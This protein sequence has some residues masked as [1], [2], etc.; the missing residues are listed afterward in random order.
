MPREFDVIKRHIQK[1]KLEWWYYICSKS[2]VVAFY[3]TW[4]TEL[5][6]L[7]LLQ[8]FLSWILDFLPPTNNWCYHDNNK[9]AT[10]TK[11]IFRHP[12][13]MSNFMQH[14]RGGGRGQN[15][16]FPTLLDSYRELLLSLWAPLSF[17][18]LSSE[19]VFVCEEWW[20]NL[21]EGKK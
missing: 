18:I 15:F 21:L 20:L 3:W 5:H 2:W 14:L 8:R 4:E 17:N 9:V 6:I 7:H 1:C 19:I 11:C 10:L 13:T 12:P 16:S